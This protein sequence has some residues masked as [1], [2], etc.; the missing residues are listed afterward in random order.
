M[1]HDIENFGDSVSRE[2]HPHGITP[3]L[4]TAEQVAQVLGVGRTT[5]YG[6]L[7]RGQLPSV[8]IGAS[9]RIRRRDLVEFVNEL[10]AAL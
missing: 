3:M 7:S 1:H 5:V 9:R 10:E 6:L 4:F 8:R 2:E